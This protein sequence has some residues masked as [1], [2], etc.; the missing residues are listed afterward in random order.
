MTCS[1]KALVDA[2]KAANLAGGGNLILAPFCTYSLTSA[3]GS[4]GADAPSGLPNITT[5]ISMTGLGTE[6]TRG[7]GVGPF[8]IFEVDGPSQNPEA[9]GQLTLTTVGIS[10][11]DAGLGVGGGIANL[12]GTVTATSAS[13]HNN[14]AAYGGGVYSDNALTLV[15]TGVKDNTASVDGGGIY[16][17]AGSVVLLADMFSGNTP[18]TCGANPPALPDC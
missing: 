9:H 14:S 13:I 17:N 16:K 7:P 15:A 2:V 10:R 8:R 5:A 4:G 1:E 12:G 3:H 18:N 11:G 6:I